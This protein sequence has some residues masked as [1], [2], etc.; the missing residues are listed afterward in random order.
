MSLTLKTTCVITLSLVAATSASAGDPFRPILAPGINNGY[1]YGYFLGTGTTAHE[2]INRGRATLI[3]SIGERHV[4][5]EQARNIR[6]ETIDRRLDNVL[7]AQQT[8][9]AMRRVGEA[10]QNLKFEKVHARRLTTMAINEAYR[11][12]NAGGS[13][14]VETRAQARLR[15][16]RQLLENERPEEAAAWL[17]NISD[18]YANTP[19]AEKANQILGDLES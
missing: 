16:A 9:I 6:E 12:Q 7:K 1:G 14:P 18:E 2:S 4:L 3:R 19:A 11:I 17:Q 15:L 8:R 5:D 13:A 10:E